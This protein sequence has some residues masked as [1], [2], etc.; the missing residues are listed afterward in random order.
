MFYM[1]GGPGITNMDFPMASRFTPSHDVVLVG[2]RGVDSSTKLN[3]P[4]VTSA[5]TGVS[6]IVSAINIATRR[7]R[8]TAAAPTG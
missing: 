2:Y 5:M 7:R 6:D 4:E 8:R 1:Q 3:C